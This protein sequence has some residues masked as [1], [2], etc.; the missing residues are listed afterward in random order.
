M[1]V[2]SN[3]TLVMKT[4][5]VLKTFH[6]LHYRGMVYCR[7]EQ[8]RELPIVYITE[9]WY[10]VDVQYNPVNSKTQCNLITVGFFLG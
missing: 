9:V 3:V 8:S 7:C 2:L 5:Q 10:T 4:H 1:C 6:Y